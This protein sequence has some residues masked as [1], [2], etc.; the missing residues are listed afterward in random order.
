MR[1]HAFMMTTRQYSQCE[2]PSCCPH[3]P[4]GLLLHGSKIRNDHLRDF[5]D[6]FYVWGILVNEE[7]VM[8]GKMHI[9]F[10]IITQRDQSI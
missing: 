4:T 8:K 5:Q 9:F 1:A 3:Q 10:K 2:T 6:P 7:C